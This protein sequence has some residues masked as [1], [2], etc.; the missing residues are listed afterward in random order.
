MAKALW[1]WRAREDRIVEKVNGRVNMLNSRKRLRAR[2][3]RS[4]E[5]LEETVRRIRGEIKEERK[6]LSI[7]FVP[8]PDHRAQ[9]DSLSPHP[10]TLSTAVLARTTGKLLKHHASTSA[11]SLDVFGIEHLMVLNWSQRALPC[12]P[13]LQSISNTSFLSLLAK[14]ANDHSH[15]KRKE[16]VAGV[17][18]KIL[19]P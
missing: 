12:Q 7:H 8:A 13:L 17:H 15:E 16:I 14:I 3:D 9:G 19:L 18:P 2:R 11:M 5:Q 4:E 10:W 1:E 6:K